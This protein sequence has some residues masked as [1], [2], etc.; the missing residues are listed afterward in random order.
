MLFR[1]TEMDVNH[2]SKIADASRSFT[3]GDH[4][5]ATG[6]AGAQC[7]VTSEKLLAVLAS[8]GLSVLVVDRVQASRIEHLLLEQQAP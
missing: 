2:D 4:C 8:L 5:G 1:Q 6:R 7:P 3:H